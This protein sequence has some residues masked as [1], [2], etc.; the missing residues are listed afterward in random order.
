MK[1]TIL[2]RL[3]TLFSPQFRAVYKNPF[4]IVLFDNPSEKLLSTAIRLN[5][6]VFMLIKNPSEQLT[7]I[8]IHHNP[9]YIRFVNSPSEK[10]Q[11]QAISKEPSLIGFI[12]NPS[13][14]AQ[15][16]S[17]SISPESINLIDNPSVEAIKFY[18]GN[19]YSRLW[20]INMNK[21]QQERVFNEIFR[22]GKDSWNISNKEF[23]FWLS[24]FTNHKEEDITA[25]YNKIRD[26]SIDTN[27]LSI[28][29][30][31]DL[32]Y[33]GKCNIGKKELILIEENNTQSINVISKTEKV[34]S[35]SEQT[36]SK[37]KQEQQSISMKKSEGKR[38]NIITDNEVVT[39]PQREHLKN[40]LKAT[41]KKINESEL[42]D[43]MKENNLSLENLNNEQIS[44]LIKTGET[45][46]DNK[47]VK[48]V[49]EPS[50]YK[51]KVEEVRVG[52][53]I[54]IPQGQTT[55]L[56]ESTETIKDLKLSEKQLKEIENKGFLNLPG[57]KLISKVQTSAG[58]SLKVFNVI[59]TLTRQGQAE[60]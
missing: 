8:A 1:P 17:L 42:L 60:A 33:S 46:T 18:I 44:M 39:P 37:E 3:I 21:D 51:V 58:Y 29:Q 25:I 47:K 32:L 7:Q 31:T 28:K 12:R 49:K 9:S 10:I 22:S 13:I 24:N 5:S 43:S 50:G 30:W 16:T 11:L 34:K 59:N 14:K 55:Q 15:V 56:Q 4:N 27:K 38:A 19:D 26:L 54:E 41:K 57:G 45:S 23:I 6:K 20:N 40:C 53:N 2:D 36:L 35:T 48:L 52:E